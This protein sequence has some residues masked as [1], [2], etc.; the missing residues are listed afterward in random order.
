MNL[1]H[2]EEMMMESKQILVLPAKQRQQPCG[3][4][5]GSGKVSYADKEGNRHTD[6]CPICDG[7]GFI[8]AYSGEQE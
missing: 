4:C 8:P 6:T 1:I 3:D 2:E 7:T 5:G